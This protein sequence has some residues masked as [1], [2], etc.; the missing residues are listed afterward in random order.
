METGSGERAFRVGGSLVQPPPGTMADAGGNG[1]SGRVRTP[2]GSN[3][4]R[5]PPEPHPVGSPRVGRKAPLASETG[6]RHLAGSWP[7]EGRSVPD[8]RVPPGGAGETAAG[9]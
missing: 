3:P 2:L 6:H 9:S 7:A 1:G 8:A 5:D 4:S